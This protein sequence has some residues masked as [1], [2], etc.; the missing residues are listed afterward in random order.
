MT[1]SKR[2]QI[3]DE[4]NQLEIELV[5]TKASLV[6]ERM[7]SSKH[8]RIIKL[9][10]LLNQKILSARDQDEIFAVVVES[11]AGQ[12]RLD[13]AVILRKDAD[14]IYR[15]IAQHGYSSQGAAESL[16]DPF[17]AAA[18]EA[19]GRLLVNGETRSQIAESY[20]DVFQVCFFTAIH[21]TT[22]TRERQDYIL[23]VGNQTEATVRRP[24]LTHFDVETLEVL[25]GQICV[26]LA[27][28]RFYARLEQSEKKYRALYENA[29]GG[30]F[31]ITPQGRLVDANPA[32][33]R[34]VGFE[35]AEQLIDQGER[36]AL[37]YF[38]VPAEFERF[39][40]AVA[41]DGKILGF[42]A[43]LRNRSRGLLWVEIS[44]RAERDA[45]GRLRYCEGY[46][47]DITEA[48][49]A[50][51]LTQAKLEAEAANEAKSAFLAHMSHE[52]R[53]PMNGILGMSR[54]LLDGELGAEERE[55]VATIHQSAESLL[56]I[57]NDILDFSKIEAGKL[58]LEILDF[59]L[60]ETLEGAQSLFERRSREKGIPLSCSIAGD[61]PRYVRGD[62][63]RLRQ[64]LL[65]LMSNAFKFTA[66]GSVSLRVSV[67]PEA[68]AT[69]LRF[70]V[71]DTGIGIPADRIDRL[72]KSFSQGDASTNRRFGGTGLG[73]A[74]S[75]S[76]VELMAGTIGVESQVGT[77]TLFWFTARLPRVERARPDHRAQAIEVSDS[78]LPRA[79]GP[80]N[81][82]IRVLLV[83]DSVIS[84]KVAEKTL[85]RM[86]FEVD[87][88]SN[89]VEAVATLQSRTYDIV[90]MDVQMPI[91][92]GFEATQIIRDP[93]SPVRD[94]QVP[95]VALT[96]HAMKDDRERC[97][98]AG[99]DDYISKPLQPRLLLEAIERQLGPR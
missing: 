88:V 6:E 49:V 90:L 30:I 29:V 20:E 48:K 94:H 57:L 5:R 86:G 75:K 61:V 15:P 44:A 99:M 13:R 54:L 60:V 12:T 83:E 37:E 62:P 77:G 87:A 73:L 43:E 98:S 65:N 21:F 41:R 26:A 14:A 97:L 55:H 23:F 18:V 68:P 67:E 66:K 45:D 63:G 69:T 91:M 74:I 39:V 72:F 47:R 71:A 80:G 8:R 95:I 11:L 92:D 46:L 78:G 7:K 10:Q 35:S 34:I 31:R 1:E 3:P 16:C 22:E 17:F 40:A 93:D 79:I 27:N 82:D 70:E 42:E 38:V 24:R 81:S 50:M 36:F 53:T 51:Q 84:R 9:I 85:L 76:L 64:I 19:K 4:I 56:S 25:V 33:A 52:I 28:V 2:D 32:F 89:G 96:A 58:D 59:D